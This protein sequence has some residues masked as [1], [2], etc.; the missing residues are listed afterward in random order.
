MENLQ[1]LD[2]SHQTGDKA[3][4]RGSALAKRSAINDV[5]FHISKGNE[6]RIEQSSRCWR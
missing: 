6:Y 3:G 1:P 4:S 5:S 2:Q